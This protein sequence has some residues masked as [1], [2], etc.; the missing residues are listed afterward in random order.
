M[1]RRSAATIRARAARA[2]S[3]SSVTGASPDARNPAARRVSA[4][5]TPLEVV[6]A[7][8]RDARGRVLLAQRHAGREHGG[9]WEFPGGKREAGESPR[10]ALARELD[11][12]LGITL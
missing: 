8:L 2:R 12:E 6:A 1:H 7:V 9:L 3:S 5:G 11:E 10:D 4:R